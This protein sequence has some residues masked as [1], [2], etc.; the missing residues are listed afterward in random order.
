[1]TDTPR[2]KFTRGRVAAC[3]AL[4]SVAIAMVVG[5]ALLFVATNGVTVES[6]IFT[7]LFGILAV[8]LIAAAYMTVS[9]QDEDINRR[10]EALQ[11]IW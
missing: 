9:A 7:G 10:P 5:A 1:M 6:I 3:V 11:P 2:F 8:L 4:V